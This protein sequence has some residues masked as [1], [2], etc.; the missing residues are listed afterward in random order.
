MKVFIIFLF[1][2]HLVSTAFAGKRL[3]TKFICDGTISNEHLTLIQYQ[4]GDHLDHML[5][6]RNGK[7]ETIQVMGNHSFPFLVSAG[8]RL[9]GAPPFSEISIELTKTLDAS[10]RFAVQ[11]SDRRINLNSEIN[12]RVF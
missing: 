1:T 12:C 2:L 4:L 10:E 6:I 11:I 9:Y 8:D 7:S 3:S 5:I